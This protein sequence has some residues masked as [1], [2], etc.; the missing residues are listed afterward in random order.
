M[1]K[2]VSITAD[3]DYSGYETSI[4]EVQLRRADIHAKTRLKIISMKEN[5]IKRGSSFLL[6]WKWKQRHTQIN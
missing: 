6:G 4:N 5:G 3:I 1:A 2:I